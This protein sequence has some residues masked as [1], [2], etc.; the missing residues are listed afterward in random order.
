MVKQKGFWTLFLMRL[1]FGQNDA[2]EV[3]T[4]DWREETRGPQP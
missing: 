4:V 1:Y 2:A 3:H